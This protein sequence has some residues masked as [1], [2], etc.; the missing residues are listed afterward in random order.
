MLNYTAQ[1]NK[2][3]SAHVILDIKAQTSNWSNCCIRSKLLELMKASLTLKPSSECL[4]AHAEFFRAVK[5]SEV[6]LLWF[7][8]YQN[9]ICSVIFWKKALLLKAKHAAMQIYDI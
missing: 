8:F 6:W 4:V 2:L 9:K 3:D 1:V 5:W 7:W